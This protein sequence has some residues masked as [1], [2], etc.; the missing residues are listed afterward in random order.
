MPTERINHQ[1]IKICYIDQ[2]IY[3]KNE[4]IPSAIFTRKQMK[5]EVRLETPANR[6]P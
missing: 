6:L 5:Q 2:E 4:F 1:V 3:I